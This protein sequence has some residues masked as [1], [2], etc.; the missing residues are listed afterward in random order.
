DLELRPLESDSQR[1]PYLRGHFVFDPVGSL[2]SAFRSNGA[3]PAF[4]DFIK[5]HIVL[6]RVGTDEVIVVG[7]AVTPNQSGTLIHVAGNC[8]GSHAEL[9]ILEV[10]FVQNGEGEAAVS[11]VVGKLRQHIWLAGCGIVWTHL[12]LGR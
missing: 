1:V 10:C 5:H 3:A 12:P 9:A 8:P 11:W 7:I 4:L 6:E 2:S